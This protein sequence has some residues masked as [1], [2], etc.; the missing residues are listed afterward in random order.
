MNS[1]LGVVALSALLSTP[2][3]AAI[4]FADN[5][6]TP[7]FPT[8]TSI[9]TYA[10]GTQLSTT[11]STASGVFGW[12]AGGNGVDW[13]DSTTGDVGVDGGAWIDL[14]STNTGSLEL[15]IVGAFTPGSNYTLSFFANT[16]NPGAGIDVEVSNGYAV[17]GFTPS[18]LASTT[19]T[20]TGTGQPVLD[21]SWE[22]FAVNFTADATNNIVIKFGSNATGAVG[23]YLD[24]VV[25]ES[26]AIPEP[27]TLML[28]GLGL[29]AV[30]MIRR[31]RA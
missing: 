6:N 25:V 12:F 9:L 3:A 14:N 4:I 20:P 21:T 17:T 2:A 23:P 30:A 27:S 8:G 18:V 19:V 7:A 11:A 13:V 29:L 31:K 10:G 26:T 15:A 16:V 22:L 28:S 1:I 24:F 5:F